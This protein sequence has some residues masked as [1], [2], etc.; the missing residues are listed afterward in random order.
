MNSNSSQ[1]EEQR[2]FRCHSLRLIQGHGEPFGSLDFA[3]NS[4]DRQKGFWAFWRYKPGYLLMG[5]DRTL[6]LDCGL[7]TGFV[8]KA[9]AE[10]MLRR[11]A[12][13]ELLRRVGLARE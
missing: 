1:P 7:V 11:A 8:D 5:A 12:S 4:K 9:K 2:C 3:L 6:C 10:T 13:D